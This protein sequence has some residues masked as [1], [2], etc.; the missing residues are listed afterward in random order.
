MTDGQ[1]EPRINARA[2]FAAF[3]LHKLLAG[4]EDP[5]E[6]FSQLEDSYS[7]VCVQAW[8]IADRMIQMGM[9][10][11]ATQATENPNG[12]EENAGG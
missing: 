6:H 2:M 12:S 4:M 5:E 1:P 8:R 11:S 3:A 10:A 9:P 7:E